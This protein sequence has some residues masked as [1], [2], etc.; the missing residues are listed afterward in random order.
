MTSGL[1][2]E[3]VGRLNAINS[4]L[5]GSGRNDIAESVTS[6]LSQGTYDQ[7]SVEDKLM[8]WLSGGPMA[9]Y[10]YADT[11]GTFNS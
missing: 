6:A 7:K 5:A 4:I 11:G 2:S 9:D 1:T 8:E 3:D 10:Q